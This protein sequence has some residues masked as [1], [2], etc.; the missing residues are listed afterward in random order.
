M[1]EGS[2]LVVY[3]RYP[4]ILVILIIVNIRAQPLIKILVY[5]FCLTISL[6]VIRG[7]LELSTNTLAKLV[8]EV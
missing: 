4:V 2:L 1:L 6:Q 8:L 3:N 5:N 7:R